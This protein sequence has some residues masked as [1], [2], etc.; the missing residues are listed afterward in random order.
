MAT[1]KD[2]LHTR[3]KHKE[4][5]NFD[6]L[7]KSCPELEAYIQPNKNNED[8]IQFSNPK[9]V[10]QLNKALLQHHYGINQWDIPEGFLCPPI[11]GRADYIHHIADLLANSNYGKIPTGSKITCVDIGVG[12]NCIYPLIG[13]KEYGWNFI[14]SDIEQ[15]AL[16]SAASIIKNN[17][18]I[19]NNID[20]RLQKNKKDIFYGVIARDEKVDITICNP[21]FHSSLEAA[22]AGKLRKLNNLNTK[23]VTTPTKNCGGQNSELWCDGGENRFVRNMAKESKK[24]AKSCFWFTTLISKQSNLK[25][26][27]NKLKEVEAVEIKTIAMGQGN[28]TSRIVAWT[29]L[30]SEE[31]KEWRNNFNK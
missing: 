15:E 3:S 17:K 13:V 11:P 30:T 26:I 28:K 14:G 24:F 19:K 23:K 5:Y 29:F 25:S 7:I 1:T 10:K 27:Y 20:L 6:Q 18:D 2:K 12:A 22:N 31:Q 8:S 21:P 4:R 16:D 9:A